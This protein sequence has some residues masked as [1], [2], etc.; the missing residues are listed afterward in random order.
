MCAWLELLFHHQQGL[1]EGQQQVACT[2][3]E[4]GYCCISTIQAHNC[5]VPARS[6]SLC[7]S[8][9]GRAG[10]VYVP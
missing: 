4:V 10:A 7:A 1:C 5:K 8:Y 9:I 2:A 6:N 3:T